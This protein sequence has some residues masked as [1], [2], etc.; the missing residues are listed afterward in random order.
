MADGPGLMNSSTRRRRRVPS[1]GAG[2]RKAYGMVFLC[3]AC[4][5]SYPDAPAP[6][7]ACAICEDERQ[8]V[9][10]SGLSWTDR[11]TL[12]RTRRNVWKGHEPGLFSVQIVPAFAIDQRAFFLIMPEDN[13]LWDCVALLDDAMEALVRGLGGLQAIADSHPHY[14]TTV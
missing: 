6:P 8:F 10:T 12:A 14:Y 2:E 13:V 3:E 4:G 11:A 1:G 7:P 5:T 9:P